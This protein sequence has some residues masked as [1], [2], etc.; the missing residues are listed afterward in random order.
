MADGGVKPGPAAG[1]GIATPAAP[2]SAG[3][4]R[5]DL[6]S[7][8]PVFAGILA[9]AVLSVMDALIKEAGSRMGTPQVVLLRYA[10]GVLALLPIVLSGR[11]ALPTRATFRRAALR[12]VFTIGT[13]YFFFKTLTLLPLAE[14]IAITFTAPFF[15]LV[16]SRLL[17]GEPMPRRALGAIAVGFLGVIVM[18]VGRGGFGGGPAFSFGYLTGL[19]CSI[20]YALSMILM[21]R[22]T[23]HDPVVALVFAQNLSAFA[24][25]IPMGVLTWTAP[26]AATLGLFLAAG[27]LGTAGH[28]AFAVAYAR[29]PASRLAPLEYTAFLWASLFGAVFF[30]EIPSPWTLAGAVLIVGACL[31]VMGRPAADG[32]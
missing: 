18:V 25:A 7:P 3:S 12:V 1:G 21:R 27:V 20:T 6:V 28:L 8:A 30:G 14:S 24:V 19:A 13:A 17:L 5:S 23:G 11:V 26:S 32:A 9:V 22:D 15:M 2:V 4:R 29:A 16:A 31:S 10:F